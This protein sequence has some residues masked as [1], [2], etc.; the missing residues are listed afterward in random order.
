MTIDSTSDASIL[1]GDLLPNNLLSPRSSPLQKLL[2]SVPFYVYDNLPWQDATWNGQPVHDYANGTYQKHMDDY[3]FLHAALT[4]PM[5]TQNVSD[6]RLFVIPSLHN[7]YDMRAYFK[8]LDLC[9]GDLCN[10]KLIARAAKQITSS[11]FF[12]KHPE[13]HLAVVSHFA[14]RKKWWYKA[15]PTA[16]RDMLFQSANIQ[17]EDKPTNNPERWSRPK[18]HVGR[19]CPLS[20]HK[21]QDIALI[22]TLK[23]DDSRF[24]DR[25][26]LCSW[27]GESKKVRMEQCGPGITCPSLSQAKLGLHVRG[28]TPSSSRIFDILLSGTVPVFTRQEQYPALPSWI[29]WDRISYFV[30]VASTR[31][32]T[33][34]VDQMERIL[35]DGRTYTGKLGLVLANRHLFDWTGPFVFDTYMYMLQATL[36]PETRRD[37]AKLFGNW[38]TRSILMLVP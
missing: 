5:R 21:T 23:P 35:A 14:H 12:Q 30:D 36:Y 28:D 3:W 34:F 19:A 9:I 8:S 7:V 37:K 27:L 22:A 20:P 25:E 38:A 2:L 26:T 15:M 33:F 16:Y 10:E 6:A 29:D 31:N 18:M 4:H 11:T 17:F 32:A 24:R 1:P 13:A